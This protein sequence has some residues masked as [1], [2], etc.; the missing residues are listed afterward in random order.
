MKK[1]ILST[2]GVLATAAIAFTAGRLSRKGEV[3]ALQRTQEF[4]LKRLEKAK[5]HL[6]EL[7][8]KLNGG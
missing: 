4:T 8:E 1:L 7:Y 5:Y 2:A 6:G 3:E